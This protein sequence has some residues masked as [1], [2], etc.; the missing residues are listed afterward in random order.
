[1]V[2][3]RDDS[4]QSLVLL[5]DNCTNLSTLELLVHHKNSSFFQNTD[6]FLREALSLI[7]D[8][9]KS[10]TALEEILVRFSDLLKEEIE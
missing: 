2:K 8:H 6:D 3:L 1:M 9:F 4:L 7:N 5:W 10:I